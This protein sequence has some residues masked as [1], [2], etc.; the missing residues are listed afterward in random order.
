MCH[1]HFPMPFCSV[2]AY[3]VLP[4]V[5]VRDGSP[6]G[7]NDQDQNDISSQV[8]AVEACLLMDP[9]Q[10]AR[11]PLHFALS[12]PPPPSPLTLPSAHDTSYSPCL[13]PTNLLTDLG[14]WLQVVCP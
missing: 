12:P 14:H 5:L 9:M 7:G 4:L 10:S 11:T 1:F 8:T 3:G 13:L 2:L 6:G